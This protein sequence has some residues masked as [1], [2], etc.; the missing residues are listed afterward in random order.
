MNVTIHNVT[1]AAV[2]I[3]WT[4][5]YVTPDELFQ[6]TYR[7]STLS[8]NHTLTLGVIPLVEDCIYSIVVTGLQPSTVYT[9]EVAASHSAGRSTSE[10]VNFTT[11]GKDMDIV[12][13]GCLASIGSNNLQA[14]LQ[15]TQLPFRC[16]QVP[17]SRAR[18]GM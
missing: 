5:Q 9:V 17:L 18:I 8:S 2:S 15:E 10:R 16:E 4:M 1:E 13:V 3:R 7:S 14:W 11:Y 12:C 6:V